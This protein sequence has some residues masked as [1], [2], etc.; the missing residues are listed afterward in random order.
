MVMIPITW[1][2]S[3]PK[4]GNTWFRVFLGNLGTGD[5]D[6]V[7]INA[8]DGAPIASSRVSFETFAGLDAS[9]LTH[10]EVDQLR[11]DVYTHVAL[12]AVEPPLM[13]IH[14]AFG[15]LSDGRPMFGGRAVAGAIY[16]IRNPLDVVVSFANHSGISMDRSIQTINNQ[17]HQFCGKMDRQDNQL[18]QKLLDWSGHVR[19]W[20]DDSGLPVHAVRYED[21]LDSPVET[22]YGAIEFAGIE[23]T[24][25]EVEMALEKS[26]FNN[27]KD[28]EKKNGFR[29]KV[30]GCPA[31][32]NRGEAGYWR[33]VLSSSQVAA[34]C[35]CHGE[36]MARFGYLDRRGNPL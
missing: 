35:C 26:R 16:F 32:F 6:P 23:A 17:N 24:P 5:G 10:D 29:E 2:A 9:D 8:L 22:F 1:L 34:V 15:F 13:K 20:I 4:S 31:F 11:P 36:T 27:L 33:Q 30:Q 12:N 19:S 21:M 18:R 28:Q 25:G 7:D 3:Y 14:D